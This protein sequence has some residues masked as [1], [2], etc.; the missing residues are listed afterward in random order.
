MSVSIVISKEQGAILA[1]A[2]EI[3]GHAKQIDVS[4]EEMCEL[5]ASC[6]KYSRYSSEA[7]AVDALYDKVLGEVADVIIVLDHIIKIFG[8][9]SE[10]IGRTIDGKI[11]RLEGWLNESTS[12]EQTTISREIPLPNDMNGCEGCAYEGNDKD[13][14]KCGT[15]GP[16]FKNYVK[17]LPCNGCK[18]VG[19]YAAL[20]VGGVCYECA[21][22]GGG[23]YAPIEGAADEVK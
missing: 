19:D 22:T 4:A 23:G 5:A 10:D 9:T 15:C 6:L 3:Y 2:R 18:H 14:H 8:M 17:A 16:R 20:E 7:R 12:S 21:G 1:R 11:A 13:N